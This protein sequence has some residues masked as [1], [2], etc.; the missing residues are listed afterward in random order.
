MLMRII[1]KKRIL[2]QDYAHVRT[3][4]TKDKHGDGT[5]HCNFIRVVAETAE[6][7]NW[8]GEDPEDLALLRDSP[9]V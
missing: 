8:P 3:H 5:F 7:V 1:S 2:Y 6:K 9:G 4:V